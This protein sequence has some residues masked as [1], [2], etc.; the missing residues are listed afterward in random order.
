MLASITAAMVDESIC[1]MGSS[2][3]RSS[4]NPAAQWKYTA[5]SHYPASAALNAWNAHQ[6]QLLP[7]RVPALAPGRSDEDGHRVA[8]R[9][10]VGHHAA[11]RRLAFAQG[12]GDGVGAAALPL[13]EGVLVHLQ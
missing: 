7:G 5:L 8:C 3:V 6:Q 12:G 13:V 9:C 10:L 1:G 11:G 4:S 2:I